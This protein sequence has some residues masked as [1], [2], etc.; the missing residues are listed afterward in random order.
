M[1]DST[2]DVNALLNQMRSDPASINGWSFEAL[3]IECCRGNL[4]DSWCRHPG[5]LSDGESAVRTDHLLAIEDAARKQFDEIKRLRKIEEAARSFIGH[6]DNFNKDF[7]GDTSF[8]DD[9]INN[10]SAALDAPGGECTRCKW[11]EPDDGRMGWW[12]RC[13]QHGGG[14]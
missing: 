8:P 1:A 13:P 14:S 2:T 9:E 6:F 7:T 11:V 3:D 10:L 12:E 4:P 5:V